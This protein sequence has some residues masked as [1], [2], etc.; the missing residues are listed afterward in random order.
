VFF[1]L[2]E[3]IMALCKLVLDWDLGC[4]RFSVFLRFLLEKFINFFYSNAFGATL[5]VLR[6]L[7]V[8]G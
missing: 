3:D 1:E 4:C 7:D 8:S 2:G 5:N 6:I